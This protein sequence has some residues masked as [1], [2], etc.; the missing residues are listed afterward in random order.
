VIL[1]FCLGA[2]GAPPAPGYHHVKKITLGGEGGWD[3]LTIDSAARRLY[4]ARATRVMVLDA[5]SGAQVGEIADTPGVHGVALAPQL[6]RGFTSNGRASTVTIFDLKTLKPLGQA[7]TGSNPDAIVYDAVTRRVFTFNGASKD[8]TVIGAADGSVSGTIALDGKPEFA[9]ADEAGRIYV[10]LEDK[11]ELL[12]IDSRQLTIL[13]RWPLAPCK[14]PSGLAMD[15]KNRRLFV[16][17]GNKLM[18]VVDADSGRVLTTLPIG[19]GVDAIAFDPGTALAFSSN[20]DGT[21]TVVREESPDKFT[22]VENVA[23]QR[24]ARTMALD[25]KTH[26]VY[27]VTAEFGPPREPTPDNPRGRPGMLPGSFVLLVFGQ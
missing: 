1:L 17:C 3:Y 7:K 10:N 8:A 4:I 18:A 5:D 2:T 11:S 12:A 22:V 23:T 15:R 9:V 25:E 21:L 26:N 20:G 6:G 19:S 27:L 13:N 14:E 24:G 16:G